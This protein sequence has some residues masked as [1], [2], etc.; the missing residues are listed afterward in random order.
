LL[1]ALITGA[2][3]DQVTAALRPVDAM[4]EFPQLPDNS[5]HTLLE[6]I[7]RACLKM[8]ASTPSTD[9]QR[10]TLRDRLKVAIGEVFRLLPQTT[11]DMIA[12]TAELHP[13][14]RFARVSA[15]MRLCIQPATTHEQPDSSGTL[16]VGFGISEKICAV[17]MDLRGDAGKPAL[18]F[19]PMDNPVLRRASPP[20]EADTNF[21]GITV[22]TNWSELLFSTDTNALASSVFVFWP[23]RELYSKKGET[24]QLGKNGEWGELSSDR[25]FYLA[26]FS[27]EEPLWPRLNPLLSN[28][29]E[30][31]V[32]KYG[33]MPLNAANE[34]EQKRALQNLLLS[35]YISTP[36]TYW[37]LLD[38]IQAP[39]AEASRIARD[40]PRCVLVPR[41]SDLTLQVPVH[42][43]ARDEYFDQGMT[44]GELARFLRK[45]DPSVASS[46][47]SLIAFRNVF[48][49]P[50]KVILDGD[51]SVADRVPLS[52][53]DTLPW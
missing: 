32:R 42:L 22:A 30:V 3:R 9:E 48:D 1:A 44:L 49:L 37:W 52:V 53:G 33:C 7:S 8:S 20:F 31:E 29:D 24:F 10:S 27:S 25:T 39:L 12:R 19:A 13:H 43:K 16:G 21:G 15:G 28:S 5:D 14:Q 45:G 26:S 18:H 36:G 50:D 11:E 6:S 40:S 4:F 46:V 47:R 34:A 23:R 51:Q 2:D 41:R 35:P 38:L 17:L